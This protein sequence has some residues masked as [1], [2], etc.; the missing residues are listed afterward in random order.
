METGGMAVE[1]ETMKLGKGKRCDQ[2]AERGQ[3]HRFSG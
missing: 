1:H 3:F 2:R